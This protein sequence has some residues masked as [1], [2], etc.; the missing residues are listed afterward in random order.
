[1]A[2]RKT[3]TKRG[4]KKFKVY[5]TGPRFFEEVDGASVEGEIINMTEPNKKKKSSGYLQIVNET[6]AVRV[7]RCWS[8]DQALDDG[9]LEIGSYVRL[10]FLERVDLGGG[11]DVKRWKIESR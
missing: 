2:K 7:N 9:F 6:G 1:M 3:P 5:D 10:T 11:Q 4:K 8:I